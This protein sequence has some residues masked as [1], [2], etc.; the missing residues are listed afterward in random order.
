[1]KR[2]H[3]EIASIKREESYSKIWFRKTL[4]LLEKKE[5]H[6]KSVIDIGAGKGEFLEI[7]NDKFNDLQLFA[8][9]YTDT[10]LEVLASKK[11]NTINLDLDNFELEG[12]AYLKNKFDLV[13][14]LEVVEHI[15][16]LDRLF[17]LFNYILKNDGHLL[18]S[19]PNMASFSARLFYLLRGYPYE[20]NHHVRFL[21]KRR[22]EQYSFF[23]GFNVIEYNNYFAFSLDII[24]RGFGIRNK[25]LVYSLALLLFGPFYLFSKLG[26]LN[27]WSNSH[28][29]LLAQKSNLP[30][31][32]ME[33][34]NFKTNFENLS[35]DAQKIWKA[36]IKGYLKQDKMKEHIYFRSYL[37]DIVSGNRGRN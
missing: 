21:T 24:K 20:E 28:M 30:P 36:R 23:T 9:D 1:M 13:I 16:D 34:H 35:G 37:I 15:F 7:L 29:V 17:L 2:R 19:T 12:L 32:G 22:I 27:S 14:C 18:V 8:V 5:I 4:Q 26:I 25:Y 3:D 10:N 31:L 11:I 33:F 6:F